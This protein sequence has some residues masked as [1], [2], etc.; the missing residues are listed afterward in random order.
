VCSITYLLASLMKRL[1]AMQTCNVPCG[2]S[3]SCP[4]GQ[5]CQ[6]A[7][8]CNVPLTKLKSNMLVTMTGPDRVMES[9]DTDVFSGAM[10]EVISQAAAEKGIK[11]DSIGVGDQ[12]LADRRTFQRYLSARVYNITQRFLP[13]GSSAL[14]VSMVVTGD[15][16][17]PPYLD[18]DVIAGDS[19]NSQGERVINT[20]RERGSRSGIAFFERV[21]GVEAMPREDATQRPTR[22]PTN[23]P[24][25]GPTGHPTSTEPS[26]YASGQYLIRNLS[27]TCD[28]SNVIIPNFHFQKCHQW[29]HH[30]PFTTQSQQDLRRTFYLVAVSLPHTGMPIS[31][32]IQLNFAPHIY[33]VLRQLSFFASIKPQFHFQH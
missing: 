20:L 4:A 19:I 14:D 30:E 31:P 23:E 1:D 9:E 24:T 26:S 29:N 7:T 12:V 22:T 32:C 13:T 5:S 3:D 33:L 11:L 10:N 8:N 2:I 25:S 18:L 21:T 6:L 15:Y 16:R 17:P 28:C 27:M